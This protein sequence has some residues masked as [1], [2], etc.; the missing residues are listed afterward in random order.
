MCFEVWIC[1]D[2][3]NLITSYFSIRK[4]SSSFILKGHLEPCE[5]IVL[6]WRQSFSVR[7][8][9]HTA[10]VGVCPFRKHLLCT[11]LCFSCTPKDR[12]LLS[13]HEYWLCL[14]NIWLDEVISMCLLPHSTS[15]RVA[16]Y[17]PVLCA[18]LRLARPLYIFANNVL[19]QSIMA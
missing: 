10:W 16:A 4:C 5:N 15:Y 18:N 6:A 19:T 12:I 8:E 11:T 3:M 7:R 14:G 17:A 13:R 1:T 2:F 9:F